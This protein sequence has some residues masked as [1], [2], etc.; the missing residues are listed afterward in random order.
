[1]IRLD[2]IIKQYGERRVLNNISLHFPKTGFFAIVGPSGCGKTT[3][4]NILSGIDDDYRGD[5]I[6]KNKSMSILNRDERSHFRLLNVGYIFQDFRLFESDTVSNNIMLPLDALTDETSAIKKRHISS[7]L[8]LISLSDKKDTFVNL[9]S[10]GEKQRVAIARAIVNNPALILCDE[11]TGALDEQNANKVMEILK[12]ISSRHLVLVVSHDEHLVTRYCDKKIKIVDGVV[13]NDIVY[14][15]S[16]IK[17]KIIFPQLKKQNMKPQMPLKTMIRRAF[18]LIKT[19]KYRVVLNN[20]MMSLGLLGVG[21]SIIMTFSIQERIVKGFSEVIEDGMIIMAKRGESGAPINAYSA[22]Y[23]NVTNIAQTYGAWVSGVGASYAVNFESFFQ[24]RDELFISST[25]HKVILPRFTTR[26]INDFYW[27]DERAQNHPVYPYQQT[28]LDS[29]EMIIGLPYNDMVG[30]CYSLR[31][32]R[33]YTSL[34]NYIST[35]RPL[36]TLGIANNDWQYEDEQVFHLCGVIESAAPSIYHT[37]HL[38]NEYV[39][40]EKMRIPSIDDG[41]HEF[42]WQMAKCY[43]LTTR[44]GPETFLEIAALEPSLRDY[45]FELAGDDFHP[46]HC[47]ISGPCL[48]QRLLVFHVDKETIDVSIL[49]RIIGSEQGISNYAYATDGG[50]YYHPNSFL[51]G[52]AKNI[53]ISLSDV[54]IEKAIDADTLIYEESENVIFD[55]P[56][57]VLQGNIQ[58]SLSGGVSFSSDLGKV[59]YGRKPVSLDEIAVSETLA[60]ELLTAREIVGKKLQI[61]VNYQNIAYDNNRIEKRYSLVQ[62]E[63]VGVAQGSKNTLHHRP[64]W[65]LGFFQLQGGI[66][67]FELIPKNIILTI[68]D[69]VDSNLL[70]TRLNHRYSEFEFYNPIKSITAGLDETMLFFKVVLLA[71]SSLAILTSFFLFF[72]VMYIT[73]EENRKEIILLDYLGIPKKQIRKSFIVC[74]II[75]SSMSFFLTAIE[76][77]IV[78][79]VITHV[80]AGYVGTNIPYIFDFRPLISILLL[81]FIISYGASFYAFNNQYSRAKIHFDNRRKY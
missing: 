80:I 31:I 66:S 2:R 13:T 43:F 24:D 54:Q 12:T 39:F 71:F 74:G 26:Q 56:L 45:V 75:F 50:Y 62:A 15:R 40:Q 21:L 32:E 64:F 52:F 78:D 8:N 41:R 10:G 27:L 55:P 35:Q 23:E 60:N 11:P 17:T 9:L 44:N 29:D 53:F 19:K 18:S 20:A 77:A 57:G 72:I 36:L 34:G 1:M 48:L 69:S 63:I 37:N 22:S 4:L 46:T 73:I 28:N 51:A 76:I 49:P 61:A 7:I 79:Y 65:S 30:I 6:F 70:I 5:Y 25:S 59:I 67:A 16:N 47:P 3:L 42:P 33:N 14:E 68:D 58:S 81:S 38:W